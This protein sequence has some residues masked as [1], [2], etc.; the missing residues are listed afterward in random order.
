MFTA[1]SELLFPAR[2]IGCQR[3]GTWLCSACRRDLP[4]LPREVCFRCATWRGQGGKCRGCQHLSSALSWVRAPFAYAGAARNAVLSLKF[5][6]GRYLA[7]LMSEFLRA[8]VA[9]AELDLVLP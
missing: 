6:S 1:L 9:D 3:R 8:A 4:F 5:R 2:C 7:P